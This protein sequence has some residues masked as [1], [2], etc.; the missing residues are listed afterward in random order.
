MLQAMW[1]KQNSHLQRR[2]LM[3]SYFGHMVLLDPGNLSLRGIFL[4]RE[5]KHHAGLSCER[6][7]RYAGYL[8]CT[9]SLAHFWQDCGRRVLDAGV[10]S[11]GRLL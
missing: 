4:S 6:E 9:P 2:M 10:S 8:W 1:L 5:A 11:P 7:G 3:M